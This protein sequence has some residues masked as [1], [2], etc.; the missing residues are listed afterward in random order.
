MV[1]I[2]KKILSLFVALFLSAFS[3]ASQAANEVQLLR[4]HSIVSTRYGMSIQQPRFDV[5]VANVAY[6]KQVFIRLK[7]FDG[8]WVDVPLAFSRPADAGRE[9]WS[10]TYNN[11]DLQGLTFKTWDVEFSVKYVVNGQTYWDNNGGKNYLLARDSGN[12]LKGVNV[13]HA[14]WQPA[15]SAY[16]GQFYGTVTVKNIAY[17]K[18]VRVV[19]ST[20]GWKTS[21]TAFATFNP[22]LWAGSYSTAS[23]PNAYGFEEWNFALDVGT[24]TQVDYAIAYTANGATIWDNNFGRN[25]KT[26]L[27]R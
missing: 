22:N 8:H 12:V 24:A 16:H 13:L 3:F 10:G 20:D 5:L 9:V 17:N 11:S 4:A 14:D 21:K 15:T 2:M 6:A 27:Q 23:N 7:K 18:Q 1:L 19:Y 26:I 25:Y